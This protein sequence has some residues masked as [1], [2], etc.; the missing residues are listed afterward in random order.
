MSLKICLS[1]ISEAVQTLIKK[2]EGKLHKKTQN[3]VNSVLE[4]LLYDIKRLNK[5][6]NILLIENYA[7]EIINNVINE[8]QMEYFSDEFINIENKKKQIKRLIKIRKYKSETK[9]NNK[10]IMHSYSYN[11]LAKKSQEEKISRLIYKKIIK[12]HERL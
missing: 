3:L 5:E 12:Q 7:E 2:Q 8:I 4:S 1:A 6:N 10:K 11:C 9:L